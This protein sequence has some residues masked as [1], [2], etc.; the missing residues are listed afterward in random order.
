MPCLS[1]FCACRGPASRETSAE[2][3]NIE[4]FSER[5]T[6]VRLRAF[7]IKKLVVTE[8]SQSCE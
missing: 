5:I 3:L 7:E 8:T 4:K 1:V 2:F 6:G